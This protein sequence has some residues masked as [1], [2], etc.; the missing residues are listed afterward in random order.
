MYIHAHIL[1]FSA[2]Y[3]IRLYCIIVKSGGSTQRSLKYSNASG[4]LYCNEELLVTLR[5]RDCQSRD[6]DELQS[7]LLEG[8][9]I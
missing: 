2:V 8:G 5:P 4:V 6:S 1:Y 3:D 9:L 7:N